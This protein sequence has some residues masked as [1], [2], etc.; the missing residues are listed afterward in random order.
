[1][2]PAAGFSQDRIPSHHTPLGTVFQQID[3]A[4]QQGDLTL[5]QAML[6]KFYV[7][8]DPGRAMP[9]FLPEDGHINT[10]CLTPLMSEYERNR[11]EI[12]PGVKAEL[13]PYIQRACGNR[14]DTEFSY[15][16]DSGR[17]I[18][19]YDTSGTAHSVPPEDTD[20]SGIPDFVEHTAFA[21]DSTWNH[22][23]GTLG[24]ADPVPDAATPYE[25][26]YFNLGTNTY[27]LT[28]ADHS[29]NSTFIVMHNNFE[30][31]PENNH[32]AGNSIGA[33]YA[34]SAHE[35]KHA[36]QYATNRWEHDAGSFAWTEMDATMIEDILFADV[37]DNLQF[38][39]ANDDPAVPG[40]SSIFGNPGSPIP[41]A[42]DHFTWKLYFS[43][44]LG[45][46][47]WV[48]V[49]DQFKDDPEK[50]FIQAMRESLNRYD[51]TFE[52]EHI[53]NI[54][55]H[56]ASGPDYSGAD[57]GFERRDLYPNPNFNWT[58]S[59]LPDSTASATALR[60]LAGNF[61]IVR[62]DGFE[63]GNARITANFD[64]EGVDIALIGFFSDGRVD[65]L[66]NTGTG[67]RS[68]LEPRWLWEDMQM[69]GVVLINREEPEGES[70]RYTL[71][72]ESVIP[73]E[74]TLFQNYPNPFNPDTN[75]QFYINR[76]QRVRI[77]IYDILGRHVRTLTDRT[78]QQGH[79]NLGFEARDLASGVYIYRLTAGNQRVSKKMMLVK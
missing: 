26:R 33:L 44:K 70:I 27:G 8:F 64:R 37:N 65:L 54:S 50:K 61:I 7:V 2:I 28:C 19:Y 6:Q 25:I 14:P 73:E 5:D 47:F 41:V 9:E 29:R 31:F 21:A 46:A 71:Q 38:L 4:F 67:T 77:D 78:Y 51:S 3:Q 22:L 36:S 57:F 16:T 34:T 49:W 45:M 11:D 66:K 63:T 56:L 32:P 10:R 58:F 24:F 55:W 42:Y 75:I 60:P 17:F 15:I 40:F 43:E 20:G 76:S 79:H 53:E 69:L 23:F 30:D 1:M 59:F 48:D 72:A 39:R 18:I 52:K 13:E 12:S 74:I 68:V 35:L 62:P